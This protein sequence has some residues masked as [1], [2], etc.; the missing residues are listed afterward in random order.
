MPLHPTERQ[1]IAAV[2]SEGIV[3]DLAALVAIPSVGGSAGESAIQQWCA[4]RLADLG[5]DVDHWPLDLA[6][7]RRAPGYPG[8]E[9]QRSGGYGC[10]GVFGRRDEQ[11]GL[12]LAGHTDVVPAGDPLSWTHD[13]WRLHR[14]DDR[15]HGRGTADMKGGLAAVLG[16]VAALTTSGVRL[17]RPLAVHPVVGEEDGG[18]GAF[19]ALR[20]GHRGAA[21]VIAEPTDGC[22]V[23]ANAGS[24]TFR[25]EVPG[26]AAHGSARLD[27]HSAVEA[28]QPVLAALRELEA[29]RSRGTDPLL[30]HLE[31]PYPISVG[32]V[33]AGEWAS[34]VPDLLVAEGR[35]GVRFDESLESARAE[36]EAA[37]ARACATDP[38]LAG[39]P[40][41]VSWPGGAF[42]SGRL[43][44]G[45]R[46]LA[47]VRT[48][49][50][51]AAGWEAPVRGA[52]YGSDLRLYAAAGVPTVQLGP[53]SLAAA[54]AVDEFVPLSEVLAAARIYAVLALRLCG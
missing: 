1:V 54:H 40:V 16:A 18:L 47:D 46:L 2:D 12:I 26:R 44:T 21:C 34:T 8:E 19:A 52:P 39:H 50:A 32:T 33:R 15:L 23:P 43:P 17:R 24:L 3:A 22:V 28:F 25:L 27:G 36:F 45:H 7:L 5:A 14:S 6:A 29:R 41:Q 4:D 20:R 13:P 38:W 9:A 42:A 30:A 11:P 51:D 10:V 53:G 31:L 49:A 48:A 37:V 35:Y